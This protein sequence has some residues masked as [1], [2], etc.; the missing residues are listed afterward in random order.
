MSESIAD[1]QQN[2]TVL[3]LTME[4]AQEIAATA[5]TGAVGI[6]RLI[7]T[8][9]SGRNNC[10]REEVGDYGMERQWE[11]GFDGQEVKSNV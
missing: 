10:G 3:P 11:E 9:M 6:P 2:H 7:Q 1:L 5:R 8:V 4:L